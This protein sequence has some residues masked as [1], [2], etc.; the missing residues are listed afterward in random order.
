MIA[1]TEQRPLVSILIPCYNAAPWI[2]ECIE[3]ALA[4]TYFPKEVIVVDDGSSDASAAI[5]RSFG[6]T[7]FRSPE[8]PTTPGFPL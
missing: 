2:A 7:V 3:S 1:Q 8:R 6:N 5:I 4:Q